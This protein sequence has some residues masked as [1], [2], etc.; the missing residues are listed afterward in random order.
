MPL[1]AFVKKFSMLYLGLKPKLFIFSKLAHVNFLSFGVFRRIGASGAKLRILIG[2]PDPI[3][4][5]P[6]T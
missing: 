4:N 3:S 5:T 1:S 6:L 2:L